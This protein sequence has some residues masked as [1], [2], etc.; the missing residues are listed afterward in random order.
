MLLAGSPPFPTASSDK[1]NVQRQAGPS[2]GMGV[3]KYGDNVVHVQR[4]E[5]VRDHGST[6]RNW[7]GRWPHA[8]ITCTFNNYRPA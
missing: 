8:A 6:H 1:L 5:R 3:R 2:R 4:W 7:L